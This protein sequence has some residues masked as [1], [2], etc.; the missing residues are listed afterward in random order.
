[1]E[2]N[3]A[4]EKE[5]Q[6]RGV[7]KRAARTKGKHGEKKM[8]VYDWCGEGRNTRLCVRDPEGDTKEGA[9]KTLTVFKRNR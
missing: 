5:D 3:N 2:K 1:V 4:V 9:C 8:L 6:K 7:E